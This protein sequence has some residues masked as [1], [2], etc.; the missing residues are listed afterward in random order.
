ML[1]ISGVRRWA[2]ALAVTAG[3]T[4]AAAAP[5]AAQTIQR[6][7]IDCDESSLCAEVGN[8]QEVFGPDY[9]VGHDEPS[10]LFYSN[11]HGCS[12]TR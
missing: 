8:Y 11:Q 7:H 12:R 6:A 9:Y 4:L 2:I 3:T 5:A 1:V 10:A